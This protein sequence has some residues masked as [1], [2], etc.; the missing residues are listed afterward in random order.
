MPVCLPVQPGRARQPCAPTASPSLCA[1]AWPCAAPRAWRVHGQSMRCGVH[2]P[3][4]WTPP[5]A[6][7]GPTSHG[8]FRPA[9]PQKAR[10]RGEQCGNNSGV[11][12]RCSGQWATKVGSEQQRLAV[13]NRGWQ[14]ATE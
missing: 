6:P 1:R 2:A 10:C 8:I 3:R 14:W 5:Q 7:T 4:P 12:A 13:G 9:A 11:S